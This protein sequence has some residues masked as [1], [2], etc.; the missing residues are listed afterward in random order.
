HARDVGD[1]SFLIVAIVLPFLIRAASRAVV[2]G[3]A[4]RYALAALLLTL[5]CAFEPVVW[6]LAVAITLTVMCL[7]PAIRTY[8]R[9]RHSV[10]ALMSPWLLLFPASLQ[11][12][13]HP[14]LLLMSTGAVESISEGPRASWLQIASLSPQ[15]IMWWGIG[16][17]VVATAAMARGASHRFTRNLALVTLVPLLLVLVM[18]HITFRVVGLSTPSHPSAA[19]PMLFIALACGMSI[20]T[21]A[22][23]LIASLRGRGI[24]SR[25]LFAALALVAFTASAVFGL[26]TTLTAPDSQLVRGERTDLPAFAAADFDSGERPR[27]LVLKVADPAPVRFAIRGSAQSR[28]GDDDILRATGSD[29]IMSHTVETLIAQ[30]DLAVNDRPA[31]IAALAESGVRYLAMES[32]GRGAT[33]V[34]QSFISTPNVRQLSAPIS[35]KGQWVWRLP[36]SPARAR[37]AP[38]A[39]NT[40]GVPH[41]IADFAVN[42]AYDAGSLHLKSTTD[43]PALDAGVLTI[44]DVTTGWTAVIDGRPA[45][46]TRSDA[47][48]VV[49]DVPVAARTDITVQRRD[50][51]RPLWLTVQLLALLAAVVMTRPIHPLVDDEGD[52]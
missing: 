47:G 52:A 16:F 21:A 33:A 14:Y 44:A 49:I 20:L 48:T 30:G 27:V 50:R 18:E 25:H 22:D 28:F 51:S 38:L 3:D 46:L 2:T 23:G 35:G 40:V 7:A 24:G 1:F 11:W 13:A 9:G 6:L 19:V 26:F 37:F 42:H 4:H 5:S 8:A 29:D 17:V 43:A 10:F 39:A 45:N 32:G 31:A 34:A 41:P 15:R 12:G 36:S